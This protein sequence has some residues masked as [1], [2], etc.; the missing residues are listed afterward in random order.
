MAS[1]SNLIV[2]R[3][4]PII[5]KIMKIFDAKTEEQLMHKAENLGSVL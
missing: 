5:D 1:Q 4:R 3:D 2:M